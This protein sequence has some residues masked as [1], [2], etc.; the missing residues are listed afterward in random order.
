[1]DQRIS[2]NPLSPQ[3][4]KTI[5]NSYSLKAKLEKSPFLPTP[6]IDCKQ[7]DP[8]L[9]DFEELQTN[10]IKLYN[11]SSNTKLHLE[12][13]LKRLDLIEF[14]YSEALEKIS[15]L[16]GALKKSLPTRKSSNNRR[17]TLSP[18][19][20][21]V[22]SY[23]YDTSSKKSQS[24]NLFLKSKYKNTTNSDNTQLSISPNSNDMLLSS[25]KIITKQ[26]LRLSTPTPT[27][28]TRSSD[29]DHS[30]YKLNSD[31][32][33][34]DTY[35]TGS[36][37]TCPVL[38]KPSVSMCKKNHSSSLASKSN[39]DDNATP[40]VSDN[41]TCYSEPFYLDT[42]NKKL[43][44]ITKNNTFQKENIDSGFNLPASLAHKNNEKI[45]SL[46]STVL[47]TTLGFF[48]QNKSITGSIYQNSLNN[49]CMHYKKKARC[50]KH[51]RINK[52]SKPFRYAKRLVIKSRMNSIFGCPVLMNKLV[53]RILKRHNQTLQKLV[54]YYAKQPILKLLSNHYKLYNMI[55]AN[56]NSPFS[57]QYKIPN[58]VDYLPLINIIYFIALPLKQ[59]VSLKLII[60]KRRLLL[61]NKLLTNVLSKTPLFSVNTRVA[62]ILNP[63]SDFSCIIPGTSEPKDVFED[64]FHSSLLSDDSKSSSSSLIYTNRG[65]SYMYYPGN[66][67][68][69]DFNLNTY[70]RRLLEAGIKAEK[71]L[72][73][74]SNLKSMA[75]NG[76]N[77]ISL[78]LKTRII[79]YKKIIL[80]DKKL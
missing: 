67:E 9:Q 41:D 28:V 42:F 47:K 15:F 73:P 66:N 74:L 27:T 16:Q 45:Q 48:Q 44:S 14:E 25:K 26:I 37:F 59:S 19:T 38:R 1:M 77:L 30:M 29:L 69:I 76:Y 18:G 57:F 13:A 61:S 4:K 60:V 72:Y 17:H 5:K 12:E 46:D 24:Q 78:A 58:L 79:D 70:D 62:S 75:L 2:N 33:Q 36:A 80:Q 35:F 32:P 3:T 40:Y 10:Y 49:Y 63:E 52:A 43:S 23:A 65:V 39:N 55:S 20:V 51:C 22:D 53:N 54:L 8:L 21:G 7:N 11:N 50:N 6:P 56:T 71:L 31:Q 34:H 64:S 68:N